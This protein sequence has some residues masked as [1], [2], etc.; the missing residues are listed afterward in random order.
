MGS[1]FLLPSVLPRDTTA[2][3][4]N[5]LGEFSRLVGWGPD[6]REHGPRLGDER[7]TLVEALRCQR[8]TLEMKCSGLDAEAIARRA[9]SLRLLQGLR[10]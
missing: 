10:V 9:V 6:P 8:L 2:T 5:S 3:I 4:L 1:R 7:T